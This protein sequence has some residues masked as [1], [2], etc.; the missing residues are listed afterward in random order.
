[1]YELDDTTQ[2]WTAPAQQNDRFDN[3]EK[4]WQRAKEGE[5]MHL[6]SFPL[7]LRSR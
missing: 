6:W 5:D 2:T 7:R 3:S 4:M 1:M